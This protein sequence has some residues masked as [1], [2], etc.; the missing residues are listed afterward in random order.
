MWYRLNLF[1]I[2]VAFFSGCSTKKVDVNY[3]WQTTNTIIYNKIIILDDIKVREI[4]YYS[5]SKRNW[6]D[7]TTSYTDKEDRYLYLSPLEKLEIKN[8]SLQDISKKY[9][10]VILFRG[11]TGCKSREY[12]CA[13]RNLRLKGEVYKKSKRSESL[14]RK[15]TLSNPFRIDNEEE[16]RKKVY[17]FIKQKG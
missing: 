9:T 3:E 12:P 1:L 15:L 14:S 6:K 8:D 2:L 17:N 13:F 7:G 5:K 11:D 16:M 4:K 10:Q